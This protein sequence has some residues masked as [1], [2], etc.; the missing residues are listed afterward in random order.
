MT[1]TK[2]PSAREPG[3][4]ADRKRSVAIVG[5]GPVGLCAAAWLAY[6]GIA[7]T[8][9][10]RNPA[11][12]TAPKAG[13]VVPRTLEIFDRLGV[14]DRV[15]EEGIRIES[16]DFLH[17]STEE[18]LMRIDMSELMT[19]TA[20]PYFL[21]LPQHEFEPILLARAQELGV[22]V[23]F[24]HR[25]A[26]LEQDGERCLLKFETD[27]GSADFEASYVVGCDG[28]HSTVRRQLDLRLQELTPPEQFVVVNIEADLPAGPLS[29]VCDAD[30][31]F[32]RVRLPKF[33]RVG[34]AAPNDAPQATEAEVRER[35]QQEI[36]PGQHF[37]VLDWAQYS[38]QGRVADRFGDGRVF[39]LGDA[40]HL[41]TPIG[42]LGLNSGFEDAFNF[43]WKLAWVLRGWA[44]P[45]LLDSY[46]SE[47]QP[48]IAVTADAMSK[49]SRGFMEFSANP[50]VN[51]ARSRRR[52]RSLRDPR[53]RW[54]SAYNGA[55]FGL[56]Y[57]AP[58]P[59]GQGLRP[60]VAVGTRVPDGT[61]VGP[62][63]CTRRLHELLG[64][65]FAALTFTG[66]P[67]S[68]P[69]LGDL[70]P[71]LNQLVIS[72]RDAPVDS[73]ARARTYFD[74]RGDL[75]ARFGATGETT[76]LVRPDD[77]TAAITPTAPGEILAAYADAVDQA[78]LVPVP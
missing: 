2:S 15:R 39:L 46:S 3:E 9:F 23:R 53:S 16:L 69:L 78:A 34:W 47:R 17:K 18:P 60:P 42:G 22:E 75:T 67:D 41:I 20:F 7:V 65:E 52:K 77:F 33:W 36:G 27:G 19:E 26:S 57:G 24:G 62:D 35:V 31:F 63:G 13:T 74:V 43:G 54:L 28:G 48:V 12:S 8:V 30:G 4:E 38:A 21:N 1:A 61:L 14:I 68:V 40:A 64:K 59:P 44:G 72:A 11:T 45:G 50:L 76:Y 73:P 70:P 56:T 55:L 49:R 58:A 71:G 5:A 10:E 32:T 6:H 37:T 66:R 51:A 25:L 29:Y